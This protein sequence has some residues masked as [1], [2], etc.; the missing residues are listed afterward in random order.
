M[1]SVEQLIMSYAI[2]YPVLSEL[3]STQFNNSEYASSEDIAIFI[4]LT[5]ICRSIESHTTTLGRSDDVYSICAGVLNLCAHYKSFFLR[6][7]NVTTKIFLMYS[8][9]EFTLNRKFIQ[10]YRYYGLDDESMDM[11]GRHIIENNLDMLYNICNFIPNIYL[12]R[13]DGEICITMKDIIYEN[14]MKNIPAIL[15]SKDAY[16]WQSVYA[17]ND[18]AISVFVPVKYRGDDHS[19]IVNAENLYERY[20][21]ERQVKYKD[22]GINP[23]LYALLLALTKV[24]ERN[25]KA[26]MSVSDGIRH[27][28]KCINMYVIPNAY[29]SPATDAITFNIFDSIMQDTKFDGFELHNRLF[30]IDVYNQYKSLKLSG[31]NGIP[32]TQL[33]DLVDPVGIERIDRKFFKRSMVDFGT[34]MA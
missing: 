15:I 28:S 17:V 31:V 9:K 34:L 23:R 13:T 18:N 26:M 11:T 24:P 3:V 2:R 19:Y 4:D 29:I 33:L 16:N 1:I 32:P 5:K 20:C 14:G 21:K 25:V 10:E 6:G 12:V 22:M 30:A 7:Y 8:T 27:I